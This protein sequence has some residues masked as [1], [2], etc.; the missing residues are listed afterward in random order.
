[1]SL[2]DSDLPKVT[3]LVGS[4]VSPTFPRQGGRWGLK[5]VTGFLGCGCGLG[6]GVGK[7]SEKV[8]VLAL[9]LGVLGHPTLSP[10]S[11]PQRTRPLLLFLS[12][13]PRPGP[14]HLLFPLP[15]LF[16]PA[17]LEPPPGLHQ[18]SPPQRSPP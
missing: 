11:P 13:V 16:L 7:R 5:N 14:S 10:L 12:Q 3:Q 4:R 8:T 9:P 17:I 1:M 6:D 18:K 15:R 2:L